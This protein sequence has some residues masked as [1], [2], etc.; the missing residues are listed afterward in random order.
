M[1]RVSVSGKDVNRELVSRGAAW[2]YRAYSKDKSLLQLEAEA[3]AP[4][5]GLWALPEADRMPPWDWRKAG[6]VQSIAKLPPAADTGA[7]QC[8][9]RRYCTQ[10]TNCAEAV[11]H[12]RQC[13]V[14]SLDGDGD[15][16]PCEA[17]C[18]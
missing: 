5:R 10:M 18:K 1:A 3:K 14:S 13:G 12:L 6:R 2:V 9:I 7:Y 11:F 16:R 8:G 17:V 15:G 4:R